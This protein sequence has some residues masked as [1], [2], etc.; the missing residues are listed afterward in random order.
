MRLTLHG[1]E[2]IVALICPDSFKGTL[3]AQ[4]VARSI[5][6]G[7]R[8]VFPASE[9][10]ELP[11]ADGGEGSSEI[12]GQLLGARRFEVASFDPLG[13]PHQ[14]FYYVD[15]QGRAY[16]ELAASSG[17]TLI[18]PSSE[19]C[20]GATTYGTGRLIR[21][22]LAEGAKEIYLFLGGSAT[23]DGGVGLAKAL[24][25]R[26]FDKHGSLMSSVESESGMPFEGEKLGEIS[27]IAF[28]Q[29]S[30][31]LSQVSVVGVADV[32]N[33]LCG[34]RGAAAVYGPQKGANA[35]DVC[36]LDA[37]L[38]NLAQVVRSDLK[39]NFDE[40]PGTG[41]AGGAGFGV[42]TFFKGQMQRG[43]PFFL[44]AV[45]FDQLS[46]RADL[47]IT[48]EGCVDSQSLK[49]K[50][51]QE[52]LKRTEARSKPLIA[53]AGAIDLNASDLEE[54][55]YFRAFGLG[56]REGLSS[57]AKALELLARQVASLL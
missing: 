36:F 14:G 30:E 44:D 26:F 22:A 48:G 42:L 13:R 39:C 27:R 15:K 54:H 49:G 8:A 10:I 17:I 2:K 6:L 7:F 1:K 34:E 50:L 31:L 46:E 52:L 11:L 5:A 24:G 18:E 41:A 45:K 32:S 21:S 4:E 51:L 53:L 20:R 47:V 33:P 19:T 37:G 43:A 3:A 28:D 56:H 55:P 38:R 57:P 25:Y 35:Q 29:A 40:Y 9:L 16:I 12:M 23:T